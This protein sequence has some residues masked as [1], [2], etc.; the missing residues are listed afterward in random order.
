MTTPTIPANSLSV[1]QVTD[2]INPGD[3]SG[4]EQSIGS[5]NVVRKLTGSLDKQGSQVEILIG[6]DLSNKIAFSEI[7][8]AATSN[9][10]AG[11]SSEDVPLTASVT[12]TANSDMYEPNIDWSYTINSGSDNINAADIK[13]TKN[14]SKSANVNLTSLSGS[15][16]ANLTITGVMTV[17]SHTVNT[18]NKN[19]ALT[20]N[21]VNTAF[22]VTAI[23]SLTVNASGTSAQSATIILKATSNSQLTGVTYRFVPTF[24]SGTGPLSPIISDDN[25]VFT[26]TAATPLTNTAIYSVLSEMYYQGKKIRSNTAVIDIRAQFIDRQITSFVASATTNNQF[27]N[28]S[29]QYATIDVTAVHNS[30]PPIYGQGTITFTIESTGDT[31]TQQT[32]SSNTS[33]KVERISLYHNKDV[34]GFGFKKA[35]VAVVATLRS[36]DGTI[37]DQRRLTGL[38]L[39]AGTYGLDI[40]KPPSNTQVGFSAQ[41]ATSIG[42]A[43]WRAGNFVWSIRQFNGAGPQLTQDNQPTTSTINI[44]ATTPSGKN[45]TQAI[46]NTCNYDIT[47]TLTFDGVTVYST[48]LNDI[49][50]KA[51]SQPYTFSLSTPATSNVQME[52]NTATSAR[53]IVNASKS[54]GTITWTKDNTNVGIETNPTSALVETVSPVAGGA[55][56][57]SVIVTGTLR[58]ASSRV[59]EALSSPTITL[60]AATSKL[61][62]IGD[63]VTKSSNNKIDTAVGI[64]ETTAVVG[65][66]K[67]RFP[68]A[69]SSGNDLQVVLENPQK[70]SIT[71]SATQASNS[72]SYQLLGEV[73]YKG[74]IRT[75]QKNV[76]VTINALAPSL[77][78]AKYPYTY[79]NYITIGGITGFGGEITGGIGSKAYFTYN[80][81]DL[82]ATTDYPGSINTDFTINR[83]INIIDQSATVTGPF[84][85]QAANT[86]AAPAGY[87]ATSGG[88]K[89]R[90]R[91]ESSIL[92]FGPLKY[93]IT[94]ELRDLN[95]NVLISNT[96]S[97]S[98]TVLPP[99]DGGTKLSPGTAG[100]KYFTFTQRPNGGY[101]YP[102][103]HPSQV[104]YNQNVAFT[105]SYTSTQA[106]PSPEFVFSSSG[107][108]LYANTINGQANLV[109]QSVYNDTGGEFNFAIPTVVD[110]ASKISVSAQLSSNGYLLGN[111]ATQDY[112][113]D[114]RMPPGKCYYLPTY[115][116]GVRQQWTRDPFGYNNEHIDYSRVPSASS[117]VGPYTKWIGFHSGAVYSQE[118][119]PL[120]GSDST[121]YYGSEAHRARH[122]AAY[123]R[124]QYYPNQIIPNNYF[125]V[126]SFYETGTPSIGQIS[127]IGSDNNIYYITN[128]DLVHSYYQNIK[129]RNNDAFHW[130]IYRWNPPAGVTFTYAFISNYASYTPPPV[131]GTSLTINASQPGN[132]LVGQNVN[133]QI[134]TVSGGLILEDLKVDPG[135]LAEYLATL[136][137]WNY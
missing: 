68:P 137:T 61:S 66:H 83:V 25:V 93:N 80:G 60:D 133:I 116:Y 62:I 135:T 117:L 85:N 76:T 38:T 27:S 14:S 87:P 72:G 31:V 120:Y 35:T 46:S 23:P 131:G 56:T 10:Q 42:S 1:S 69:K 104:T 74:I 52:V 53:V 95:N 29:S 126:M 17:G 106:I 77:T 64:Y 7:I 112:N 118:D 84:Y 59:I 44:I 114:L 34:D 97:D 19:I 39:R 20:V 41:T 13:I 81:V 36:P 82:V 9:T 108:V 22:Q 28:S 3:G 109:G 24:V 26:A 130:Y 98:I 47:G 102:Q 92:S 48:V 45:A 11:I 125:L 21:A 71:A 43:T 123:P 58:D 6:G 89:R 86:D 129:G 132:A 119:R 99:S 127:L 30:V 134:G 12:L 110:Q 5:N 32:I 124:E 115:S 90:D 2:E 18:C 100:G 8:A 75:L 113:F 107:G 111:S 16:V 65:S 88:K 33:T 54:T 105:A 15:K 94:Y 40:N 128:G 37:M 122:W 103:P 136:Y 63:N 4:I 101:G 50:V 70:I 78:I 49:L 91:L 96:V 57:Q 51:E 55:N 79:S 73:N 121:R 67:F